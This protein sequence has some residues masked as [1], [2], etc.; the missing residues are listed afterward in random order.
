MDSYSWVMEENDMGSLITEN[1][2]ELI[3]LGICW[4]G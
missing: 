4:E 3:I 1:D 2:E